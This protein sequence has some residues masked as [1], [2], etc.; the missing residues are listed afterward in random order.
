MKR[1]KFLP[2][3][4]V[5]VA[6][7][8]IFC[9]CTASRDK[10]YQQLMNYAE[11]VKVINTH[12]HQ[13][14]PL[15]MGYKSYHFWVL[16]SNSYLNADVV[17]AGGKSFTLEQL[18]TGT[19][20]EFWASN[21][22]YLSFCSQTSYYGQFMEGIK[23]CYGYNEPAFTPEGIKTLSQ[24]IEN[25]Y[26]N[27][28]A[29]FDSCFQQAGFETML[30]DQHWAPFNLET[31]KTYFRL[32]FPVNLLVSNI[33]NARQVYTQQHHTFKT[34]SET[35]GIQ[36]INSLDDYLHF[37][38]FMLQSAIKNG[39]VALKNSMAY[40]RSIYYENTPGEVATEL[41]R[42][43]P[44]LSSS[45]NKALQDF[46]FHWFLRKAAEYELP[47]QIHTGYLA[48]NGN[49]LENGHPIHLNSLFLQHPETRFD[50]F[51]GG[52]PWTGEFTALGKMFPNVYLNLV[53]LP[54]ISK[55]RAK[56]TF[57]E[58]LDTMPYNK[59]LWGG[60][61]HFIEEAVGS[62]EYGKQ[63]VCEVLA[64]RIAKNEMDI[65]TAQ[66]IISAVFRENALQC[67]PRLLSKNQT[68]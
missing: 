20:D 59:I 1:A 41:F 12:E 16:L 43:S 27:Y 37:A 56:V 28:A 10:S 18:N 60:D 30:I 61:C 6:T 33:G 8:F 68:Y 67:F 15:D 7:L 35:T 22:E 38:D 21:G 51:H 26:H 42:K 9:G 66:K 2:L 55:E 53:W 65:T 54:Q 3:R 13:R 57:N 63:V 14:N 44:G 49:R 64:E 29:W 47:M 48:G 50:L 45:E 11:T 46:M 36:Q 62:L 24:Q 17:S 40:S 58:M 25:S 23:K 19:P 34:F 32:V 39:A 31:D 4:F 52:F 5:V